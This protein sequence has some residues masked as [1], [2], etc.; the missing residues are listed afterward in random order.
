[1][2]KDARVSW[3]SPLT[4]LPLAAS[5]VLLITAAAE[6]ATLPWWLGLDER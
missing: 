5:A 1:V 3:S 6:A 2:L 4:R